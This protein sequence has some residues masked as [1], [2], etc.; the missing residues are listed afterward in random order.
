MR[1][2]EISSNGNY[3]NNLWFKGTSVGKETL[4]FHKYSQTGQQI[5][6]FLIRFKNPSMQLITKHAML[7]TTR[8]RSENTEGYRLR[9]KTVPLIFTGRE[10]EH[11]HILNE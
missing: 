6:F 9:S 5:D 3:R 10:Q 8:E 4:F 11:Y 1:V 2:R 7:L